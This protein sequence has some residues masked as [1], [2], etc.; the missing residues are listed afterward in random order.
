MGFLASKTRH[1][2]IFPFANFVA[3]FFSSL[4]ALS[5]FVLLQFILFY[6]LKLKMHLQINSLFFHS[7]FVF[8][9]SR[10]SQIE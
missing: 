10:I 7:L 4:F 9:I 3:E 8:H 6:V 2:H 5:A 1:L